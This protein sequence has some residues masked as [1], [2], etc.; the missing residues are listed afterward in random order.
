MKVYFSP[1]YVLAAHAFDTTRKAGWIADS[2]RSDPISGV[3]LV[4]PELLTAEQIMEVHS[5]EY[6]TAVRTGEP[7]A[8]R[9]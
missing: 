1:E 4:A 6:V 7:R 2:L 5:P 3:E 9:R 8:G